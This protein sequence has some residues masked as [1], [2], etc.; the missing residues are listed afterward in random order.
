MFCLTFLRKYTLI[1]GIDFQCNGGWDA[2][3]KRVVDSGRQAFIYKLGDSRI[4]C[5]L[6][7]LTYQQLE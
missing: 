4:K 3:I 1:L 2:H 7:R 5:V 6:D